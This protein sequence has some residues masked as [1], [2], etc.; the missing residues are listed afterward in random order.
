MYTNC[1][2]NDKNFNFFEN[3]GQFEAFF[4]HKLNLYGNESSPKQQV[5]PCHR[6][7][8]TLVD[9]DYLYYDKNSG[10]RKV[11]EILSF[12]MS[13]PDNFCL[14]NCIYLFSKPSGLHILSLW[15]LFNVPIDE[16]CR[17]WRNKLYKIFEN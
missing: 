17:N 7:F 5:F 6:R 13:I 15:T 8:S 16:I 2:K 1:I 12:S 14:K 10:N 4:F 11:P 3:S 9:E